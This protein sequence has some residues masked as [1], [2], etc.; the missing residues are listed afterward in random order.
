M[1]EAF[2]TLAT[3][4]AVRRHSAGPPERIARFQ[5]KKI[6]QV[7]A[8]AYERVPYYRELFDSV[9]LTPTHVRA[10]ADLERIPITTKSDVRG[11]DIEQMLSRDV[12]QDTLF[13]R[14]TTGTTGDQCMILRTPR[15]EFLQSAVFLRRE[16]KSLGIRRGDRVSLVK[17]P[18][19]GLPPKRKNREKPGTKA[20]R[21]MLERRAGA[22]RLSWINAMRPAQEILQALHE[23]K[24]DILSGY[25]GILSSV[26][27]FAE[28]VYDTSIKPRLIITGAETITPLMR[29]QLTRVFRAPVYD[30]YGS[31]EFGRIATQCTTTGEYHICS[32]SVAIEIIG[33]RGAVASGEAGRVIGTS[34][35]SYAMPFIR[36]D[37]GDI[38][39]RGR[40]RC[41]CGAPFPTLLAIKGRMID[42]FPMPDGSLLHPW[43][44]LDAMWP[45]VV[46]W[47]AKYRILQETT[48]RIVM[49]VLVRR[50]PTSS[51][52]ED[53]H[54]AALRI[55]GPEVQFVFSI[56]ERLDYDPSA[57]GRPFRS[58]VR[59]TYE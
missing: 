4:I 13:E 14:H 10:R 51:E 5:D 26:A 41:A 39:V 35:H 12:E 43:V 37:L 1:T 30:T 57:K 11:R 16:L 50:T 34:L 45:H 49:F 6:R 55:L 17:V 24:P 46:D 56:V 28:S 19:R 33:E 59:S 8:H 40:D 47:I 18:S 48:S 52:L 42:E 27:R 3:A 9:G 44:L 36:F 21:R 15:E 2:R 32:D 23:A 7:V 22:D 25:P 54:A 20:I 31:H 38:A 53:V 58:L 29:D